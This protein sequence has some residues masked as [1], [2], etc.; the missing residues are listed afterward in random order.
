V[1][2]DGISVLQSL[3]LDRVTDA[4][5][6]KIADRRQLGDDQLEIYNFRTE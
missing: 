5:N 3:G 6:L 4:V 1:G 2:G